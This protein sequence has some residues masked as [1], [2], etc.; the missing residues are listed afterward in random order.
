[1]SSSMGQDYPFSIMENKNIFE[2]TNQLYMGL[3][4]NR[5]YSQL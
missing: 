3:S 4:E 5:V 1:M 2:T